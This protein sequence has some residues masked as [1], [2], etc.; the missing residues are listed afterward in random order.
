MLENS[1]TDLV[2]DEGRGGLVMKKIL[3]VMIALV[4]LFGCAGVPVRP[5]MKEDINT[6][7]GKIEGNQFTGIRYPFKVS[8]PPHL[9]MSTVP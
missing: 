2:S 3:M 4:F 8:V 1:S 9:K 7:A 6:P 5:A